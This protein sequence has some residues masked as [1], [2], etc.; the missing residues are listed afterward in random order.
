[1]VDESDKT[2]ITDFGLA[3]I[4]RNQHSKRST[5]D[6]DGHTARW[7]APEVLTSDPASKESD[8]FSF[9]MVIVEVGGNRFVLCQPTDPLMKVFTG[10]APF[11]GERTPAVIAKI[12]TGKLPPRP[13]HPRFTDRLWELTQRCLGPV[14]LDRPCMEEVLKTLKDMVGSRRISPDR[15]DAQPSQTLKGDTNEPFSRRSFP[16]KQQQEAGGTIP[17]AL[18]LLNLY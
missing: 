18:L 12:V 10:E 2:R 15:V 9:G 6:E 3:A 16:L 4:A 17:H 11:G 7:C 13:S 1:M 14:P 5:L 8:V